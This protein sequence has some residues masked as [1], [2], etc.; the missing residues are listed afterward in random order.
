MTISAT[1][2]NARA[3]MK[4]FVLLCC[5]LVLASGCVPGADC[6]GGGQDSCTRVLFVGNSYTFVNDLPGMFARLARSG[7]H[8]VQTGMAAQGGWRLADHVNSPDTLDKIKSAKW[9]YI[10]LQE[11]SQIPAS[12]QARSAQM[13]PAARALVSRV[14]QSGARPI[15]FMTWAHRA[16]WPENGLNSCE[17]MQS[18]IDYG[19]LGIA[20]ELGA[21]LAPVGVAW[22]TIRL[23]NPELDLW[24]ADGSH[25]TTQ[26]SYLAACVFYA[27]IFRQG[28]EGLTYR[29][30]LTEAAAK[31][32]QAAAASIV[33]GSPQQWNLH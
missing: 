11:Q 5:L 13:Y 20:R 30:G 19:Y 8:A 31:V 29:A 27:V 33:L 4:Q 21:P 23:Q 17:D 14:Q 24:Q 1:A 7:G 2:D 25:P 22:S 15:F 28:P 9:D 26:G 18:Q 10:V 6:S 3:W 12:E 32:L 16:G